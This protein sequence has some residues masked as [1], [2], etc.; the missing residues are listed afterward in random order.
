MD[1]TLHYERTAG[2]LSNGRSDGAAFE[3]SA[4]IPSYLR[5]YYSWAYVRPRGIRRFDRRWVTNLILWG[6][7]ARLRE[8][9]FAALGQPIAG[10]TLQ[11][12]CVYGDFTPA[13]VRCMAPGAQLDVVDVVPD[14]LVNLGTKLSSGDPV[15]LRCCD[16]MDLPFE[17]S[18]FDRAV[19][20]FLCHEQPAPV[21]RRSLAEAWRVVRPGG[22]LVVVDYHRPSWWHPLRYLF[23]PIFALEPF[24]R[25]MWEADMTAWLPQD[26][27]AALQARRHFFGRLYQMV[28][29]VRPTIEAEPVGSRDPVIRT[30]AAA[31][32]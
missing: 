32:E 26:A 25:D 29:L 30:R 22:R 2:D 28:I 4:E 8:A 9:T 15:E 7:F 19:V 14:Q 21:R 1:G 17:D 12:A 24:A 23:G 18:T 3:S 13:L 5:Q 10:R 16:A 20:F 11:I 31:T 6:N 27:A